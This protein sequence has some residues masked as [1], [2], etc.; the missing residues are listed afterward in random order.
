MVHHSGQGS[1]CLSG[2]FAVCGRVSGAARAF[3]ALCLASRLGPPRCPVLFWGP[4]PKKRQ[5]TASFGPVPCVGAQQCGLARQRV[6]TELAAPWKANPSLCSTSRHGPAQSVPLS[7]AES[8]RFALLVQDRRIPARSQLVGQGAEMATIAG[9]IVSSSGMSSVRTRIRKNLWS[10]FDGSSAQPM[11]WRARCKRM[12]AR[13]ARISGRRRSPERA[14]RTASPARW[15]PA[16]QP[17]EHGFGA[18]VRVMSSDDEIR[19]R[20][21]LRLAAARRNARRAPAPEDS[22]PGSRA[23]GSG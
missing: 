10:R 8:E 13:L 1:P 14:G 9:D 18:I 23:A 4:G 11:S 12:S 20:R 15:R 19:S 22:L 3:P 17:H 7:T 2:K 6:D 5:R 16:E 21:R